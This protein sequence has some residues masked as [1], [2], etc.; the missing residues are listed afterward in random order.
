MN[1][2]RTAAGHLAAFVTILIWGTTFISTKVLLRTFSPVEILFIR[3]VMGYL[4]LWL[5]CPRSLRLTSARQEGLYAAA[6]FCGVTMYYLLEN[7]ALT[8]TLASNV[9]VIISIAPFFTA[10]LGWMFL[11]GE[12]PHFRFFAGFLL[13]MAG[14]SL[15]SFGNE[16]AL[17]L[18]P[19]GDLLAVAAAVIW[20]V[21]STLTKKISALGHGTVQSTRRTF[22]YGILFMV[23]ALTFMDFYVT[24]AQ[25]TEKY[26][27]SFIPGAGRICTVLRDLEH[28]RK[29]T[30]PRKDQRIHLY[31]A[32][33]HHPDFGPYIK[34][35]GNNTGCIG[36]YHDTGRI[37]FIRTENHE[38]RRTKDM[39]HQ[40]EKC[41]MVI[42]E[43]LPTGIIANT[44]GIMGITLGKKLPET[45]G[46]DVS[47]R[48]GRSHLG[49]IAI[50]VPILKAS[51][52]KLKELRLKL[53]E[54]SFSELTVVDFSNVAQ[55]C[56]DYDEFT[57]KA[58]QTDGDSFQYFGVGICGAK[59]LV[60]KLTGNLPLLR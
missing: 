44:A 46:P 7:I 14:I 16:A 32:G 26:P 51:K 20:T 30:G 4:A 22:F 34:R 41:V 54:P 25:F 5:A 50:P 42:D 45:V 43:E 60:N 23:P 36:N 48:N 10:I 31:G 8:Y 56:N 2:N 1:H 9:G 28:R 6:G 58:A 33:H 3:F 13:A 55:S 37:I 12:R 38:K 59:K 57:S 27:E 53:Y 29:D 39:D 18:N 40:N 17:S 49:I 24:P 52:E 15:I 19:T 21:Y 47:D 35:T 11:G